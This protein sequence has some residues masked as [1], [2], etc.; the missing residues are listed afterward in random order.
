V[1][2]KEFTER[3]AAAIHGGLH[4]TPRWAPEYI[5]TTVLAMPPK[6]N[7][8]LVEGLDWDLITQL[9]RVPDGFFNMCQG[10]HENEDFDY[11]TSTY[12]QRVF[13]YAARLFNWLFV[14]KFR[15][16]KISTAALLGVM[17]PDCMYFKGLRGVLMAN[18]DDTAED[19][20]H[21]VK[22]AYE[23]LPESIRMPLAKGRKAGTRGIE[24]HHGGGIKIL[25]AR[26][27]APGVGRSTDRPVISEFGETKRQRNMVTNMFPGF[28]KRPNARPIIESTPGRLGSYHQKMWNSAVGSDG[29]DRW[30]SRFHPLFLKWY[31]DESCELDAGPNFVPTGE[32]QALLGRYGDNGLTERN[33]AFRRDQLATYFN[34]DDRLFRSKFPYNPW[35]GWIGGESPVMPADALQGLAETGIADKDIPDRGHGCLEIA[36]PQE[37]V[38]YICTADPAGQGQSGDPSALSVFG[39]DYD[40]GCFDEVATW[41]GITDIDRFAQRLIRVQRRYPGCV[42]VVESNAAGVIKVLTT[43]GT[44][45]VFFTS[46]RHAGWYATHQRLL[47]AEAD[48]ITMLRQGTLR[49][50]ALA[51]IQQLMSY[52]GKLR[53]KRG[54]NDDGTTHHYDR[55][56]TVIIAANVLTQRKFRAQVLPPVQGD[57]TPRGTPLTIG[58]FERVDKARSRQKG[59]LYKDAPSW[60][61]THKVSKGFK[62]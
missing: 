25:T 1:F 37:G 42:L 14:T 52:D 16:A 50:R 57:W 55:A 2:D 45:R 3:S 34:H 7:L 33:L 13:L 27:D 51:T 5:D 54:K 30:G 32:E 26:G 62:Q 28:G 59:L 49:L 58:E 19:L 10:M 17:L 12:T 38:P 46:P 56:R 43:L 53:A 4:V 23:N 35:D 8:A 22:V 21:R 44:K 20:F 36:P 60:V 29:N 24:F 15:Q 61:N 41:E 31:Q 6:G 9:L 11:F 40:E 18:D 48:T 39:A 47:Q